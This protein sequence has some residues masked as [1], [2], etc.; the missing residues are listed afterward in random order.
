MLVGQSY[1]KPHTFNAERRKYLLAN[2]N[3]EHNLQDV[4]KKY[5][6]FFPFSSNV[7]RVMKDII[8]SCPKCVYFPIKKLVHSI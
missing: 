3:E 6:T 1:G 7:K 5:R 2:L 8:K 4:V